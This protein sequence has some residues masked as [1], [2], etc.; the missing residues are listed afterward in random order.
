MIY[1]LTKRLAAGRY[2]LVVLAGICGS[3]R[4]E[5]NGGTVLRVRRDRFADLGAGS[6]EGFLTA[7]SLG[8]FGDGEAWS[9]G[10]MDD[11]PGPAQPFLQRLPGV[12]G[13]TVNTVTGTEETRKEM[14]GRYDPD[15]ESMEGAAFFYVCRHE[16]VNFVQLRAVSNPVG[17]RDRERWEI[18]AALDALAGELERLIT[19][20]HE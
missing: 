12:S 13:I 11:R 14:Q 16:K 20:L 17:P 2:D 7:E 1:H 10:W 6:P 18:K 19:E 5:F 9:A 15:T 8:L 4:Q 3:Y